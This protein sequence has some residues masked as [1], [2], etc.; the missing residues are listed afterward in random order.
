M[1]YGQGSSREHAAICPMYLGVK[2]V[3]A[4]SMER[5]H[6]ANLVNFGI[7][8]LVFKNEKDYDTLE[9]ND[10]LEIPDVHSLLKKGKPLIIKN[11]TKQK[12]FEVS[13]DLSERE[14]LILLAGGTLSLMGE[15][16][17]IKITT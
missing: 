15:K 13:Y 7:I 10:E 5:I 3:I 14:K 4:K 8:P 16:H 17:N 9:Q 12:Q 1:S 6:K 2:A 11:K